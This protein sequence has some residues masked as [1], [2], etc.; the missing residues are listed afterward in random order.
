MRRRIPEQPLYVRRRIVWPVFGAVIFGSIFGEFQYVM[1]SVWRSYLYAMFGF[2]F[3]NLQ[4][5]TLIVVLVSI[6]N[7]Y[8]LLNAQNWEW[9]WRSFCIGASGGVYMGLYALYFMFY[10]L[11]MDLLMGEAVYL[12]Y[13]VL[14]STCFSIMCGTISAISSWMF[15]STIYSN[16]KGE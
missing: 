2:L 14:V 6:L 1:K 9:Q 8:V 4:L 3:V 7:T 15:V 5:L 13:M 12:I 11:E 16:I 10:N